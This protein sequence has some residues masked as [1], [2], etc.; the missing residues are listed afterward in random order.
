[1]TDMS[2]KYPWPFIMLI[3]QDEAFCNGS[4]LRCHSL[5][6]R[7]ESPVTICLKQSLCRVYFSDITT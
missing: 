5:Y 4:G 7:S 3:L 2:E 6:G 1:M